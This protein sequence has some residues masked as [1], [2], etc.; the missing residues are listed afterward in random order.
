MKSQPLLFLGE[1]RRAALQERVAAAARRWRQAWAAQATDTFD[2]SC[3]A[4]EA[5]GFTVPVAAVAT[6]GWE[7]ELGGDRVAVLLLPHSTFAWCVHEGGGLP[8]D[9][10]ASVAADSLAEQLEQ[11]VARSLLLET[12]GVDKRDVATVTRTS[13]PALAD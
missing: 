12:C 8:H 13:L 7:L 2:I 3:E 5:G 11:E 6:S 1:R 10:G 4:P 9:G